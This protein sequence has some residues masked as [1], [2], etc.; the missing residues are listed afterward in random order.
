MAAAAIAAKA[1]INRKIAKQ[2]KAAL[3]AALAAGLDPEEEFMKRVMERMKA[4]KE[5][6]ITKWQDPE[7]WSGCPQDYVKFA[8]RM[9]HISE[10]DSFN[11][12]IIGVIIAAGIVVGFQ[13]YAFNDRVYFCA[14]AMPLRLQRCT[15]AAGMF[16]LLFQLL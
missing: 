9:Q 15:D 1:A 3:E 8:N 4:E 11:L 12:F 2:K 13:T 16:Q 14:N 6:K 10:S 7:Q 5:T